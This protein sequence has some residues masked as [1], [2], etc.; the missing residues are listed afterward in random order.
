MTDETMVKVNLPIQR[1]YR[2]RHEDREAITVGPGEVEVPAWV[3]KEW[4]KPHPDHQVQ[5]SVDPEL[6]AALAETERVKALYAELEARYAAS[7]A[8]D[9][10][11]KEA[12]AK[13]D[14]S[15]SASKPAKGKK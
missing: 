7:A 9:E 2:A 8:S 6:Q 14:A 10:V 4:A 13:F 11:L 1:M 15:I 5:P 3:A 12:A